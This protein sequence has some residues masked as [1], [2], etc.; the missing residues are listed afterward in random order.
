VNDYIQYVYMTLHNYAVSGS[1]ATES[2]FLKQLIVPEFTHN[3]AVLPAH[4][5]KLRN[6][7]DG[8]LPS[9]NSYS[10]C[11]VAST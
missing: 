9:I 4:K 10:E 3:Q 5:H 8:K 6:Y 7:Y 11:I 1:S 2:C